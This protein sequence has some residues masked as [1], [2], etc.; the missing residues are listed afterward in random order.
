MSH[1]MDGLAPILA[2]A[3]EACIKAEVA[4]AAN[5]QIC[6]FVFAKALAAAGTLKV[7]VQVEVGSSDKSV[8]EDGLTHHNAT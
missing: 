2:R 7:P 1:W 8:P 6:S 3:N 5:S 4:P